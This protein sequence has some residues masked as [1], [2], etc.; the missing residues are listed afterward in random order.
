M[1]LLRREDGQTDREIAERLG[2]R[3]Q[4]GNGAARRLAERGRVVR[5]KRPDG[6]IANLRAAGDLTEDEIKKTVADRLLEDGWQVDVA[7]GHRRLLAEIDAERRGEKPRPRMV[8][9]GKPKPLAHDGEKQ[10]KL[11]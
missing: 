5:R 4:S 1:D 7:D 11:F 3:Q 6:G 10:G 2:V 9:E 8:A